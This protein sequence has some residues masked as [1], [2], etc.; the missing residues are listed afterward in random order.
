M[1]LQVPMY[2]KRYRLCLILSASGVIGCR[3]VFK[4]HTNVACVKLVFVPVLCI[5]I[6]QLNNPIRD[7]NLATV[8][9][10]IYLHRIASKMSPLSTFMCLKAHTVQ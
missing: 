9:S 8:C 5:S 2:T 7:K 4:L 3:N 10:S 1:Y 6:V